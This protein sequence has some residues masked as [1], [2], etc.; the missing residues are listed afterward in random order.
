[1]LEAYIG[2]A[3][4]RDLDAIAPDIASTFNFGRF[5]IDWSA[6]Q[7]RIQMNYYYARLQQKAIG[8]QVNGNHDKTRVATRLGDDFARMAAVLNIFLPGMAFIYNGEELNLHDADISPERLQ[9]P[10][11]MRD[12]GRTPMIWDANAPNYG[13]SDADPAEL[14]LPTNEADKN[15]AVAM[16]QKD[17]QSTL[18]LFR[19]AIRLCHELAVAQYGVYEPL[20]V[21]NGAVLAYSRRHED[22]SLVV[23]A[24]FTDDEQEVRLLETDFVIAES[25]LSSR[26]VDRD[27]AR[28]DVRAGVTLAPNEALVITPV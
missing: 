18:S 27:L 21:D 10:N 28:V 19:E 8:N 12:P 2:E 14:W 20:H 26:T 22:E 4:L 25:I 13:F 1:M 11:G 6:E 23:L 3:Q 16:Q 17:P 9:D 15:L 24:N 5:Y 7:H